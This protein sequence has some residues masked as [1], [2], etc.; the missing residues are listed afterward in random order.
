MGLRW[1]DGTTDK[2]TVINPLTFGAGTAFSVVMLAR[3]RVNVSAGT[4]TFLNGQGMNK[5]GNDLLAYSSALAAY[6]LNVNRAGG[7]AEVQIAEAVFT[8][9]VMPLNTWAWIALTYNET[10]GCQVFYMRPGGVTFIEPT[11]SSQVVSSGDTSADTGD[12]Y[13][14]NRGAATTLA[15]PLDIETFA[16]YPR[17]LSRG[18]LSA[19]VR[20]AEAR[21]FV[22]LGG[23]IV[24]FPRLG[25]QGLTASVAN[26]SGYQ[27][28]SIIGLAVLPDTI[29]FP[30]RRRRRVLVDV[31]AAAAAANDA[32]IIFR[33]RDYV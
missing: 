5:G 16:M 22:Q 29:R 12:L 33:N 1:T 11:Y 14:G 7:L 15:P 4:D 28:G 18:D 27:T 8:G 9:T 32:K 30:L 13:I 23:A 25:L 6:F 24:D 26:F 20:H 21:P 10:V 19:V 31:V 2:I 3:R 17:R